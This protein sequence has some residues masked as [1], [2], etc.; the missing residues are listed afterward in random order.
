MFRKRRTGSN[1]SGSLAKQMQHSGEGKR[2]GAFKGD[3][4]RVTMEFKLEK[5]WLE[6]Q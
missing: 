6:K 2:K 3:S 1:Q 4:T 5:K